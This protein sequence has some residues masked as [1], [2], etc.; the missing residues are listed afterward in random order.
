M[1]DL[2]QQQRPR[3]RLQTYGPGAL[4][5]AEL[6]AI[7]LGKGTHGASALDVA[8]RLLAEKGSLGAIQQATMEELC[9]VKAVGPAKATQIKAALEL[10]RRLTVERPE[11]TRLTVRSPLDIAMLMLSELSLLEQEELRVVLLNTR[12]EVLKTETIY[13]GSVSSAQIRVAEV[14]KLAIRANAPA[15]VAVHNH[16]SGDPTPSPDD[17]AVTRNLDE[18]GKLLGIDLLDHIVIGGG[19]FVSMRQQKLGFPD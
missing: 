3:E 5:T 7:V 11:N 14:M 8:T 9:E 12:N 15:V 18:A 2:P 10:G 4:S 13:R 19:R 16:P 17:V 1:A 6:M